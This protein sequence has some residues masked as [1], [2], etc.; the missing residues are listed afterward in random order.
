MKSKDLLSKAWCDILFENR[1][2]KY[3][4]YQLRA[5]TGH[6][7]AC[8]VGVLLGLF[9]LACIPALIAYL[10]SH[11]PKMKFD[12]P[13]KKIVRFEGIKL[14]EA[15]PVRRPPQKPDPELAR[16][17]DLSAVPKE[18]NRPLATVERESLTPEELKKIEDLPIDSMETIR[19]ERELELAKKTEQ[20][21]GVIID[22]IPRYPG[23][24]AVLMKWLDKNVIYPPECV[25]LKQQ[26]QVLV[27]FI[28]EPNGAIRDPRIIHSVSPQLDHEV[29]RVIYLMPKWIPGKKLGRPI[30]SQVT[31]PV[32]FQLSDDSFKF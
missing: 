16:R 13:I 18:D 15:R 25:R 9:A 7:Y 24:L 4:A 8:A 5:R 30:R 27:A 21:T 1:N 22:S 2:K 19:K 10:L 20:T 14:K 23:G 3:G 31:L 32:D 29:L 26:G 6:R 11:Q 17:D 28:I 12:D